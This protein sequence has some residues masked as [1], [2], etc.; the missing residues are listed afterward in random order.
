MV[1]VKR[2][3]DCQSLLPA[4]RKEAD[5]VRRLNHA[6]YYLM[7]SAGLTPGNKEKIQKIFEPYIKRSDDIFGKDDLNNLLGRFP[8]I[9]KQHYRLWL[10]ST[11]VLETIF[12]KRYSTWTQIEKD[13][14]ERSIRLYVKNPS[15]DKSC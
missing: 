8:E 3:K 2:Y 7:T 9:E 12:N 15:F 1:Q 6:R 14:I 5:K 4:L 11:N 13:E 10:S